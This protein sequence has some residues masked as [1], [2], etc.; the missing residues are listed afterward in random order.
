MKA[1]EKVESLMQDEEFI[2]LYDKEEIRNM[3]KHSMDIKQIATIMNL[4]QD[5]VSKYLKTN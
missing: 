4:K 3:E 5:E 2:G 1:V